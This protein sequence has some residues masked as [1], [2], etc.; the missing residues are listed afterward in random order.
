MV[1]NYEIF[2]PFILFPQL[3]A[4]YWIPLASVLSLL[5]LFFIYLF[6]Y[7]LP[8]IILTYTYKKSVYIEPTLTGLW[9]MY[10]IMMLLDVWI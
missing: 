7:L 1:F 6:I 8:S 10:R 3:L 2:L 5:G 4:S 9:K